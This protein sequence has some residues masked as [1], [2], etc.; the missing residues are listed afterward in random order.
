MDATRETL[1]A[2]Y[3]AADLLRA[4]EPWQDMSDTDMFAV[5]NPETGETGYCCIM[6][7]AGMEFGL[8]VATDKEGY[9]AHLLLAD[10]EEHTSQKRLGLVTWAQKGLVVSFDNRDEVS[11]GERKL[12]KELGLKYRGAKAWTSIRRWDPGLGPWA[13]EEGQAKYLCRVI[14]EALLVHRTFLKTPA[15]LQEPLAMGDVLV[16]APAPGSPDEP[17]LDTVEPLPRPPYLPPPDPLPE[18]TMSSLAKLR[19]IQT[20]MEVTTPPL[21]AGIQESSDSRM[22]F[23]RLLLFV[24]PARG[25]VVTYKMLL[26]GSFPASLS[27][28]VADQILQLGFAPARLVVDDPYLHDA[29]R[30]AFKTLDVQVEFGEFLPTSEEIAE[31]LGRRFRKT[32]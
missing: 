27:Q 25:L 18:S 22:A 5:R 32:D 26:P 20:T 1:L 16:R 17:W 3:S 8:F 31:T 13:L 2:V 21:Q 7:Q 28:D 14:M 30:Q 12:L 19:I 29:L 24:E 9:G 10:L 23:P 15:K 6:G 11:P 4:A